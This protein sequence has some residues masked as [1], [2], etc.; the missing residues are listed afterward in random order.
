MKKYKIIRW[1]RKLRLWF[2]GNKER[3]A[4]HAI[5]YIPAKMTIKEIAEEFAKSGYFYN[6]FSH[7][8]DEI[9]YYIRTL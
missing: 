1:T 8:F 6:C 4:K 9:S 2:T 3:E 5:A 7:C